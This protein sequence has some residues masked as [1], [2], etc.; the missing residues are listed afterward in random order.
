MRKNSKFFPEVHERAVRLVLEHRDEYR[1]LWAAVE[2]IAPIAAAH[3]QPCWTGSS[4]PKSI[5]VLDPRRHASS[6]AEGIRRRPC[7]SGSALSEGRRNPSPPFGSFG[8]NGGYSIAELDR[9]GPAQLDSK[10]VFLSGFSA[11]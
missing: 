9:G 4:G 5:A 10:T 6:L 8:V 11:G 2:S 7:S 1:S 3:P